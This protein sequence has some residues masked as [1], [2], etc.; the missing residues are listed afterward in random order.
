MHKYLRAIGFSQIK[1]SKQLNELLAYSIKNA[2]DK[3]YSSKDEDTMFA[4]YY[5]SFGENIGIAICG[6]YDESNRFTMDYYYPYGKGICISSYEELLW[7]DM[8]K[9]NPMQGFV[10][11]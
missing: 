5:K 10:M 8:Q 3:L 1:N 7:K 4:Q 9:K 2:E 6:E 11:R